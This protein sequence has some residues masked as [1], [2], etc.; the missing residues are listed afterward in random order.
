MRETL[1]DVGGD[2]VP[3]RHRVVVQLLGPHH[4]R[5]GV[6]SRLEEAP[7]FG[8]VEQAEEVVGERPSGLEPPQLERRLV[9]RE[10]RIGHER[11][12]IGVT[13]AAGTSVAP[14]PQQ[15]AVGRAELG[16]D[17]PGGRDRRLDVAR[18][19]E[20]PAR[21][22]ERRDRHRVPRGEH[23]VVGGRPDP[24][25]AELEQLGPGT[26]DLRGE[27]RGVELPLLRD[28]RERDRAPQDVGPS[29]LP[30]GVAP[31]ARRHRLAAHRDELVPR[32]HEEPALD[33]LA[34]GVLRG[35]EPAARL[36]HLAQEV[37]ERLVGDAS[38]PLV[39][40]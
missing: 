9:E 5:L 37:V 15:P 35:G 1:Q 8:V 40:A 16:Q 39:D 23:L 28:R 27:G 13:R 4:E 12:V 21:L 38:V 22:G 11:V 32:P 18:L 20:R 17:E 36:A 25:L 7:T 14:G 2:G 30:L 29:Q 34:V 24:L 10:T 31:N 33:A 6:R 26:C 3:A 19:P